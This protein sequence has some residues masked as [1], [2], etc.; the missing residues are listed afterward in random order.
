MHRRN[1]QLITGRLSHALSIPQNGQFTIDKFDDITL[2]ACGSSESY[3]VSG[4]LLS[5]SQPM[6]PVAK[7]RHP[8]V[9]VRIAWQFGHRRKMGAP[10]LVEGGYWGLAAQRRRLLVGPAAANQL[11]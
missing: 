10:A 11:G 5:A 1:L 9:I 7:L 8:V 4:V 6:Q 3:W 2:G